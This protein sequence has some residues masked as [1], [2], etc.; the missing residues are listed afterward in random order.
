LNRSYF[1]NRQDR[2]L[3]F[4][5]NKQLANYCAEF[6]RIFSKH[7]FELKP[8]PSTTDYLLDWPREMVSY[9]AFPT[10]IKRDIELFQ[11]NNR[12]SSGNNVSSDVEL[13][14]MIQSGPLHIREEESA[15]Y[16]LFD[17]VKSSPR[18]L[19]DLT[20]GYFALYKLY[21]PQVFDS[22]SRWR[23]LAASPKAN[24][25]YG[26]K[27][28]SGRIPHGYTILESQFWRGVK[29]AHKENLVE[30]REWERPGWTYHAKGD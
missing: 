18:A 27:G 7:S 16:R 19:I 30:L 2:Y 23:I 29:R 1:V 5:K 26:S 22:Q 9:D 17:A 14:P 3:T 4:K 24:G 28:I 6:L 12:Q 10:Q 20:S 8:S 15:L 11:A 25:F 21:H 13:I